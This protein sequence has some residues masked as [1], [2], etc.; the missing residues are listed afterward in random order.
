MTCKCILTTTHCPGS[1]NKVFL[2]N[3]SNVSVAYKILA[4]N[5]IEPDKISYVQYEK[6]ITY[7]ATLTW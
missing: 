4:Y 7:F 3:L 2:K 1:L 5:C 6:C